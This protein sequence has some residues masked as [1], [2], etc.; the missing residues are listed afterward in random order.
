PPAGQGQPGYPPAGPGQP[1]YP[2][3]GDQPGAYPPPP[4][5]EAPPKK[6]GGAGKVVLR[7]VG[8]VVVGLIII[9]LKVGIG[10]ALFGDKAKD[11]KAGDCIAAGKEVKDEGTTET[12]ADVVD[13][14]SS[15]AKF[16]VVSRIDGESSP[17]SKSCDKF[18]KEGEEFYV[19]GSSSGKG[20][21]LCLR[22]K[23]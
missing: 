6:K 3:V 1:G 18:F 5:G 19:F 10:S 9:G 13:C 20:Y 8:A 22:P 11:A 12:D 7:I 2:A 14:G 17:D 21:L 4:G 23:A 16:T 15:E